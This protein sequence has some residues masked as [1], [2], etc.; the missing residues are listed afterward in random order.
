[1]NAEFFSLTRE[2]GT[3]GW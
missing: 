3:E 2:F 1:L